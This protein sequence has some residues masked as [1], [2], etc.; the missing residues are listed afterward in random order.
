M[1]FNIAKSI[2]L[3]DVVCPMNFV[4]T[5]VE[6]ESIN[7]GE[8]LEI[9]LDE[10]EAMLNVPRSLKE[11]GHKILKVIPIDGMYKIIVEKK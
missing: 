3:H 10:G 4:K 6:L 2:N 9:F 8:I 11:E 5:K 7:P 1:E